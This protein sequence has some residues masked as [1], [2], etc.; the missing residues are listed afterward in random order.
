[1]PLA[2]SSVARRCGKN[3][4]PCTMSP[5]QFRLLLWGVWD[6]KAPGTCPRE[7]KRFAGN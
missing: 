6:N 5:G 7:G 2:L 1:M 3:K 4:G